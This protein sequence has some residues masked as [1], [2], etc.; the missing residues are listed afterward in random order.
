MWIWPYT[1]FGKQKFL[2]GQAFLC[3]N[4]TSIS[5]WSSLPGQCWDNPYSLQTQILLPLIFPRPLFLQSPSFSSTP[6]I[7]LSMKV[8][9]SMYKYAWNDPL[10]KIALCAHV[11]PA[12]TSFFVLLQDKTALM[13]FLLPTVSTSL[14]PIK[15]FYWIMKSYEHTGKDNN[16]M[17]TH[18]T[19]SIQP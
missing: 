10:L 17:N 13:S 15:L 6:S 1:S 2:E 5:M 11:P 4:K 19:D 7:S 3:T 12:A 16:L 14:L 8:F 18:R 9:Q